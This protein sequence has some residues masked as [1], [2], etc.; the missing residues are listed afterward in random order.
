[1]HISVM[2]GHLTLTSVT[3]ALYLSI[4]QYRWIET[5]CSLADRSL[6]AWAGI[7]VTE[8]NALEV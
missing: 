6:S 4:F 5:G 3:R 7:D 8:V 2:R 1:M